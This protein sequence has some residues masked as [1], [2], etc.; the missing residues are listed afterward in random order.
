MA[1][2]KAPKFE[3][4][5]LGTAFG[6]HENFNNTDLIRVIFSFSSPGDA[7]LVEENRY[8]GPQERAD[9]PGWPRSK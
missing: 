3:I 5:M 2:P 9:G 8:E 6:L 4:K 7:F 1:E